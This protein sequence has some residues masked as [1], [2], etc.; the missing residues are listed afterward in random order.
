MAARKCIESPKRW[1]KKEPSFRFVGFCPNCEKWKLKFISIIQETEV[2]II[3]RGAS[4]CWWCTICHRQSKN[5]FAT[6]S[7]SLCENPFLFPCVWSVLWFLYELT[8]VMYIRQNWFLLLCRSYISLWLFLHIR[9]F[10]HPNQ[11]K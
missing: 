6:I 9:N 3:I 8:S 11:Q 4:L 10:W 1:E 5:I 7:I 2:Y